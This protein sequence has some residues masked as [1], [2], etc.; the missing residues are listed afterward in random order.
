VSIGF[1]SAQLENTRAKTPG[2]VN[3]GRSERRS[4]LRPR[5]RESWRKIIESDSKQKHHD[6]A[7][8]FGEK[9]CVAVWI[10]RTEAL[11]KAQSSHKILTDDD[12]SALARLQTSAARDCAMAAKLL[13][14]LSLSQSVER[15]IEPC[16]WHFQR[17]LLGKPRISS[18]LPD[19]NFSVSHTDAVTVVAVSSSLNLGIDVELVDQELTGNVMAGS[20]NPKELTAAFQSLPQPQRTREFIRLWTQKEAYTKLLGC[21]HSIEFS[22]IECQPDA[23]RVEGEASSAASIHFEHFYVPVDHALYHASLAIEKPSLA[24]IDVRLINV[25]GPE[26]TNNAHIA[27]AV[28]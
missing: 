19:V 2:A 17:T 16:E 1:Q 13:L 28:S 14:R 27:P 10:A 4:S 18:S 3:T 9:L 7:P 15:R 12:R 21:G 6:Q 23:L 24:S 8:N 26:G 5:F 20:C 11:L 22:S 25:L